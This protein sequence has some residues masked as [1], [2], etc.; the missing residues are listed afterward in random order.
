MFIGWIDS[1][2]FDEYNLNEEKAVSVDTHLF[3]NTIQR[4]P[5]LCFKAKVE[6]KISGL[7]SIYEYQ[8]SYHINAFEAVNDIDMQCSMLDVMLKNIDE[9]KLIYSI[10]NNKYIESF[11]RSGFQPQY[12][13]N[14]F[15]NKGTKVAFNFSNT[16]AKEVNQE[17]FLSIAHRLDKNAIKED[18]SD[19]LSHDMLSPSSL[20]LATTSGYLHSRIVSDHV[21]IS[22]WVMASEAFMDAEKLLRAVL[23]YRGLR[24]MA[25]ISPDIQEISDLLKSY[26]FEIEEN[27]TL[28][29][30]NVKPKFIID[31]IYS[32]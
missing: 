21:L 26:K 17:N 3:S 20:K 18:R 25:V 6:N 27:Y 16:H 5:Q 10:I 11:L 1:K 24:K 28:V 15:V 30:K 9:Q 14:K 19:L 8:N 22:P 23:Y 31:N 12:N 7:S 4:F 32:F 2:T 29:S 13:F